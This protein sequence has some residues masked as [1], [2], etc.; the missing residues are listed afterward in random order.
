VIQK[1]GCEASK[2]RARV[3]CYDLG[4]VF[5]EGDSSEDMSPYVQRL[6]VRN[7]IVARRIHLIHV[8]SFKLVSNVRRFEI[9]KHSTPLPM[10]YTM[11]A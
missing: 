2:Q 11:M 7:Y 1:P 10:V 3:R 5:C 9:E 4:G 8:N 6:V